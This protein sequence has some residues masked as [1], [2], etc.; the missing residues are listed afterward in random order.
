MGALARNDERRTLPVHLASP[1]AKAPATVRHHI[2]V[3]TAGNATSCTP[4][5]ANHCAHN[6]A[7][8][9]LP[10]PWLTNDTRSVLCRAMVRNVWLASVRNAPCDGEPPYHRASRWMMPCLVITITWNRRLNASQSASSA[11]GS[12][13]G[14]ITF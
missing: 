6:T 9:L 3:A 12:I 11:S 13:E 1:R 14:L 4:T 10:L 7:D 2:A 8:A 5:A